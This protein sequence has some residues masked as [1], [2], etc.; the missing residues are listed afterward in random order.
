M[1]VDRYHSLET[2]DSSLLFLESISPELPGIVQEEYFPALKKGAKSNYEG[3]QL[4]QP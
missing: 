2:I 3:L 1:N 4:C